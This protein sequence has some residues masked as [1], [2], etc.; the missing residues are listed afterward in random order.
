MTPQNIDMMITR[1]HHNSQPRDKLQY[2]INDTKSFLSRNPACQCTIVG[3]KQNPMAA[4]VEN[5][6]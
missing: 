2:I 5:V 6:L 4:V 3:I 1:T